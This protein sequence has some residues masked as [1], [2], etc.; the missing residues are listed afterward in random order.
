M[1]KTPLLVSR[2]DVKWTRD[3]L[4]DLQ[5]DFSIRN[6][7]I[8]SVDVMRNP[9]ELLLHNLALKN[10]DEA[11]SIKLSLK[12]R[13]ISGEFQGVL[14]KQ[15]IDAI[16]LHNDAFPD[17][18]LNGNIKIQI[19]MDTPDKS[20]AAGKL[21]GRDFIFPWELN[22]PL[23][24]NSFSLSA[25]DKSLTLNAA[26]A[27]FKGK[28][29]SIN[30]QAALNEEHL[31]M[32]FD[33]STDSIELDKIIET[34]GNKGEE[35]TTT[36]KRVGKTWDLAVQAT[37]RLHA[38]SLQY[39]NYTWTPFESQITFEN[40]SLGIAILKA[41]LCSISTPGKISF[42]DG[43]IAMDFTMEANAQQLKEVL[44]CLEG[45][46][47]QMTGNLDLKASISGEG[48]KDNLVKSLHGD[49]QFRAKDGYIY[50]DARAAKLLS[51]LNVTDIFRGT[52]PDLRTSGFHYDSLIVKGV[53]KKGVLAIAPA[54]LEAPIME[55]VSTGTIDIPKE[56]VDLQVL[57]APLQA[58][59][60]IQKML[61]LVKHIIPSS[62]AAVPVEVSGD[63]SDIKVRTMSISSISIRI[64]DVMM[65]ALSSP[66]RVLERTPLK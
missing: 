10:G 9:D 16:L 2:A 28:S 54:K 38:D 45:G 27:V 65:D 36:E 37:T 62:I 22:K 64:F 20:F 34:L 60:K 49:L 12:K 66:V 47:Q 24:I 63:F 17:A 30:G 32:D 35:E 21:D 26:E 11:A 33:V 25:S 58:V 6:G 7:P 53:M 23:L 5:G 61:P 31:S 13:E 55:I 19:N 56:K 40:K 46:E 3:E 59:N 50:Q 39:R 41:E 18:W 51:L 43:Q 29:Y 4:L 52:I 42:H 15:T 57:V 44:I 8:F 48:T 1:F 14:S